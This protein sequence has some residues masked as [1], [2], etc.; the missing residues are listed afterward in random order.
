METFNLNAFKAIQKKLVNN[1][2]TWVIIG[3]YGLMLRGLSIKPKDIDILTDMHGINFFNDNFNHNIKKN[4]SY[5]Y[6]KNSRS[7]YGEL[8]FWGITVEIMA[9]LENKFHN[10][11]ELHEG[12]S[13]ITQ[14][15]SN[16]IN[17]PVVSVDYELYINKNLKRYERVKQIESFIDSKAIQVV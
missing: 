6:L 1:N 8:G 4:F 9:E 16:S 14:I 13:H 3:S 12:L 15:Q 7:L 17:I 10:K 2:I 11:W 5:S